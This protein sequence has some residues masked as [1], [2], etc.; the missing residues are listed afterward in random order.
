MRIYLTIYQS[1]TQSCTRFNLSDVELPQASQ[2]NKK[3]WSRKALH[4]LIMKDPIPEFIFIPHNPKCQSSHRNRCQGVWQRS[5]SAGEG[6]IAPVIVAIKEN[7]T[8]DTLEHSPISTGGAR[9]PD[10]VESERSGDGRGRFDENSSLGTLSTNDRTVSR[11][12]WFEDD[13]GKG[14]ADS[15][16]DFGRP[17]HSVGESMS[18]SSLSLSEALEAGDDTYYVYTDW[19][20]CTGQLP[21]LHQL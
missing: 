14:L 6:I 10:F 9:L 3:M 21:R 16:Y 17:I 2:K 4:T 20:V 15:S 13:S 12:L 19:F 7:K 1:T 5:L 18:C 8:Q 11:T